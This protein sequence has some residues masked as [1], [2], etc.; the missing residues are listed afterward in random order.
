MSD[1]F[2]RVKE[3][4]TPDVVR[5]FFP[6]LELKRDG[7]GREKALCPFHTEDTPSFT[8]FE[9][10]WKCFG[11]GAHGSNVD[12]LLKA[13]L[14][15]SPLEAAKMIAE[16]FGIEVKD[17]KA[18]RQK[19]LTLAEYAGYVNLPQDFLTKTFHLEET[20]TGITIPYRDEQGNQVGVQIRHRL[21]KSKG[22]DARFSWKEGKPYLYGAWAIPRWKERAINRL[23]LCEGASD[24]Q[25]CWRNQVPAL[26]I[27]GASSFKAEWVSLLL[28]FPE[29]A[30]IQEPGDAAEKFVKSICAALKEAGFEG[31]V[32]AVSLPEK[33]PR[34]LWLKYGEK[35]KGELEAAVARSSVIDPYPAMPLT[36]DLILKIA[37]LL[38]RHVFFKDERLSLLI[39]TW[40]L[41]TYVYDVF[42]FFGYLWINSPVKRCGKSL[43]ED[44]LSQLCYKAT[45]RLSNVSEASIFRLANEGGTLIFDEIENLKSEDRE[46]FGM[47]MS[48]LNSGFQAGGKVPRVEKGDGGYQVVYFNAFC[49]KILAGINRLADTIEDRAFKVLMVPKTKQERVERF[50]LRKQGKELEGLR[51]ELDIWR[52]ERTEAIEALYDGIGEIPELASLD[53]RFKDISEPLVAIATYTDAEAA[54]GQERILPEL[55]SLLLDMAGK[56]GE[57]EKREAI[58]AFALLAQQILGPREGKFVSTENL[59]SK[60]KEIEDLSWIDSA[61]KLANFL[62]RFDLVSAPKW[63]TDE[64]GTRKQA[65]GYT[66]TREWVTELKNRYLPYSPDSEASQVS[67]PQSGSGPEGT[68]GSVTDSLL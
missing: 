13:N 44:I 7:S 58:G 65:R 10:G 56:R 48:V 17:R 59:L 2:T 61:K 55:V 35:F 53:D 30:I 43:L 38:R 46:K 6:A 9:D 12:L 40:V 41:G 45:P 54:N 3:I 25:A 5:A 20:H 28:P 42:T 22:K 36:E 50:N 66:I 24:V 64:H 8:V 52:E 60:V 32:K 15:S 21:E 16:R 63:I 31:Q 27:P 34:D 18:R 62:G 11:C 37:D 19:P 26:G 68:L 4:P 57:S 29:I 51:R 23:L 67:Q 39:A 49:P 14:A 1:L 47:M 33:D